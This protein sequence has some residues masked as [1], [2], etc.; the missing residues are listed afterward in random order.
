MSSAFKVV[1]LVGHII[2]V[3]GG[4]DFLSIFKLFHIGAI[5]VAGGRSLVLLM[6]I[7]RQIQILI[8]SLILV[9][10]ILLLEMVV[11]EGLGVQEVAC[12]L[13]VVLS[14]T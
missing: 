3:D 13:G 8:L 1:K 9:E 7:L 2:E 4:N 10:V 6:L 14:T 12:R 5:V 11:V